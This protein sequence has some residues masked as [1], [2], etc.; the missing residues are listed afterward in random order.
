[1]P[2]LRFNQIIHKHEGGTSNVYKGPYRELSNVCSSLK[3]L[4]V[5]S[6]SPPLGDFVE[7]SLNFESVPFC[8]SVKR[9]KINVPKASTVRDST[10]YILVAMQS[11][12]LSTKPMTAPMAV[13]TYR[14]TMATAR[15]SG[16]TAA[17]RAGEHAMSQRFII[18]ME[19]C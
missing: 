15:A 3:R 1:M 10:M 7:V 2:R 4:D 18:I 9:H 16:N 8:F 19:L 12:L 13:H 5:V 6:L 17:Y 14:C 11:R